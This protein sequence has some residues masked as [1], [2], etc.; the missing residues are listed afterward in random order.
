MKAYIEADIEANKL[1]K[2]ESQIN[3]RIL[4]KELERCLYLLSL[5]TQPSKQLK[6][7]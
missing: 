7:N 1:N 6:K 2:T 3:L 5:G 4:I